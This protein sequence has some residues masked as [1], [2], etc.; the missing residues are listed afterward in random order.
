MCDRQLDDLSFL[1]HIILKW[2]LFG[3]IKCFPF[4][5]L[6]VIKIFSDSFFANF[7][8]VP[9]KKIQIWPTFSQMLKFYEFCEYLSLKT[10]DNHQYEI[11]LS[12]SQ[13]ISGFFLVK[14]WIY[15][16]TPCSNFQF[17]KLFLLRKRNIF[18]KIFNFGSIKFNCS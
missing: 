11:F 17:Q 3:G 2:R 7:E 6:W 8:V 14:S 18:Q 5:C 16:T 10:R 1:I 9:V 15:I 13:K 12:K 4:W